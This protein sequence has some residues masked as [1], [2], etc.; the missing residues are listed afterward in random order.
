MD[1]Q[2]ETA[3]VVQS[4]PSERMR[5]GRPRLLVLTAPLVMIGLVAGVVLGPGWRHATHVVPVTGTFVLDFTTVATP[6][7][8]RRSDQDEGRGGVLS[9]PLTLKLPG[10]VRTTAV[11]LDFGG[12]L[13]PAFGG[14]TV[15]HTWGTA[16]LTLQGSRCEGPAAWSYY[17]DPPE[18]F[19]AINLDCRDGSV[20]AGRLRLT[21]YQDPR[22]EH[23]LWRIRLELDQAYYVTRR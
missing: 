22:P 4:G 21:D 23:K 11:A 10:D 3:D 17:Y 1:V 5:P 15:M 6:A 14:P 16:R 8:L 2:Q 12:S 20:L 19:G 9:G 7:P 18:G 13:V